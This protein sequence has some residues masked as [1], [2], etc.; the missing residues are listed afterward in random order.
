MYDEN[1][2][3]PFSFYHKNHKN[4][5]RL[6][7]Y[8]K[9]TWEFYEIS[10]RVTLSPIP[11]NVGYK[12]FCEPNY[13][14]INISFENPNEG[15]WKTLECHIASNTNQWDSNWASAWDFQQCDMCD[16]QRCDHMHSLI[17]AFAGHLNILWVKLLTEHHLRF[18]SF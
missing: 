4:T 18:L 1:M 10:D 11:K 17:R 5:V 12:L 15:C 8:I 2:G 13:L 14:K 16:Q 7:I 6:N 9:S 3:V